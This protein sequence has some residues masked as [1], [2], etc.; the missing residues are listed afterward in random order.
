LNESKLSSTYIT[1]PTERISSL[2]LKTSVKYK[3][4]KNVKVLF[5]SLLHGAELLLQAFRPG[6]GSRVLVKM[7]ASATRKGDV[8]VREVTAERRVNCRYIKPS[9]ISSSQVTIIIITIIYNIS[10]RRRSREFHTGGGKTKMFS[11]VKLHWSI[12]KFHP[13]YLSNNCVKNR[14]IFIVISIRVS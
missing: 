11:D 13:V 7:A 5:I 6:S 10:N 4:A 3:N 8:Y 2:S 14:T 12:K 1:C 9:C